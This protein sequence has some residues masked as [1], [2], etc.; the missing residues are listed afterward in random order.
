LEKGIRVLD[1][2]C[3]SGKAINL[4]A[5]TFPNSF[6]V[7]Y[8]LSKEAIA[9]AR[10]EAHQSGN[11]N[12]EFVARDLSDFDK[13]AEPSAF[14]LITSFDAIHDQ[15]N[16]MAV[17]RG[18]RCSLAEGGVYLAQDIKASSYHSGNLDHP[19]GPLLYTIS[20]MHCMTVSLAQGG[21][22]LGAM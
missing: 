15:A 9:F 6:F 5:E 14:D 21:E 20:C 12:V 18:I 13:T 19:I 2:G 16:P 11:E 22:G 7:G 10:S 4:L 8:D 17:L 1:V 3:G